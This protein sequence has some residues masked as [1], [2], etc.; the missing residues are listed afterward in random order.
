MTIDL[1]SYDGLQSTIETYLARDDLT[2]EIPGFISLCENKLQRTLRTLFN[3]VRAT[4]TTA[5][6]AGE[7]SQ[8]IPL[9]T[10]YSAMRRLTITSSYTT[11]IEYI[12]ASQLSSSFNGMVSTRPVAYTIIGGNIQFAPQPDAVYDLEMV[13]YQ[14]ITPLS[15]LEPSNWVLENFPDIYLYGSLLEAK[16]FIQ[17]DAQLAKWKGFYEEAIEQTKQDDKEARWNGAPLRARSSG[18]KF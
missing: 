4:S 9:P 12:T 7:P 8:Y 6:D 17:D 5:D 1:T 14:K 15:D 13:Y 16:S 10:D 3:E 18:M 2:E 11:N